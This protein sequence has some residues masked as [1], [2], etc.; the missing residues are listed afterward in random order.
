[1]IW[2]V[3][4]RSAALMPV[5]MPRAASTLTWKSV[6]KLSRFCRTMRSMPSC[7]SRS[8][9]V[10]TQIRPRPYL[11]MKF[12]AAGV[13]NCAG[14]D[15]VAFVLA[16]G[17]VHDDDHFAAADVGDDGFDAVE[18]IFHSAGTS[19][20]PKSRER[21]PQ[22]AAALAGLQKCD[23]SFFCLSRRKRD[24][25]SGAFICFARETKAKG[26]R[27]PEIVLIY[28]TRR[29]NSGTTADFQ[30]EARRVFCRNVLRAA[31]W[32]WTRADALPPAPPKPPRTCAPK[33]HDCE[34]RR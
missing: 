2:M 13:T 19:V 18:R 5:V 27:A 29:L 10:G 22:N 30:P 9:V 3:S 25:I 23:F 16:V 15:Q 7:C 17:V 31:C 6:R 14:H 21:Q 28:V 4:A 34:M 32:W 8:A 20:I 26:E 12:T 1:M 33:R 24:L 11:A